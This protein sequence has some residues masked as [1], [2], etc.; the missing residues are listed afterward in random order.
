MAM[1]I[2]NEVCLRKSQRSM[3][4]KEVKGTRC[5]K[6]QRR[7]HVAPKIRDDNHNHNQKLH[8]GVIENSTTNTTKRSSKF[9]GV[10]R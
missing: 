4:E 9:R 5:V 10:S 1:M 8:V 3:E 6:R 2:E 7:E